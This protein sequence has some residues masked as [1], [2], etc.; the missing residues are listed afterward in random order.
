MLIFGLFGSTSYCLSSHKKNLYRRM[1]VKLKKYI[2]HA[3]QFSLKARLYKCFEYTYLCL[4][5]SDSFLP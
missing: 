2:M 1:D 3:A 4:F 5:L